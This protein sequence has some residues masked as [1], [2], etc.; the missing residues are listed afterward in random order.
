MH[1]PPQTDVRHCSSTDDGKILQGN[2]GKA[3]RFGEQIGVINCTVTVKALPQTGPDYSV[4]L[5][6]GSS[7]SG[8]K[9]ADDAAAQI[10]HALFPEYLGCDT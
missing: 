9:E 2:N 3:V 4:Y 5:D 7:Q 10:A 6:F 1:F 8:V